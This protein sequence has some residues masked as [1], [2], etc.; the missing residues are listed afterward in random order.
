VAMDLAMLSHEARVAVMGFKA[1][2]ATGAFLPAVAIM[3]LWYCYH[4]HHRHVVAD[5]R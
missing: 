2:T 3:V 4:R 1:A 5:Y